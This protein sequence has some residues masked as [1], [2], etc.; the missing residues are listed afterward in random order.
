MTIYHFVGIKGTGM[1]PL[2]QILHD[3]NETVQGSDVEKRFF[4]Q[5]ALEDR[6]IPIMTFDK[7]NINENLTVIAGNAFPDH[8]EEIQ[9]ARELGIPLYR[10]FDFLGEFARQFT[11][12]A[13][14]GT[15][16]KTSTTGLLSH[17]FKDY[18]PTSYL[19][20]DGTGYAANN[21]QYFIFE[22]CEYRRH[23]LAYDPDYS[24]ITNI[25]YDHTD[26]FSDLEDVVQAFQ[27]LALKVK[28]GVIACGDDAHLQSIKINVPVIYYGLDEENDF[29]ARNIER[30]EHGT[31]FDVLVR[32]DYY[33]TFTIPQHGTHNVLN[34]LAVIAFCHYQGVP[35]ELLKAR[36]ASFHGVKRR[37]TEK[38]WGNQVIVDDYAHHP[39]EISATI[40]A[41][42]NKYPEREIVAIF[43]PHTYTRTKTFMDD[44][45]TSLEA[46]DEVYLCDIFGSAREDSGELTIEDLQQKI[47]GAQI[48]SEADIDT[49]SQHDAAVLLF[50]GAGDIQKYQAAYENAHPQK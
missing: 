25:D 1:S 17:V 47:P 33:G 42:K 43:Q 32:N 24:I 19:I 31:T 48:I 41:A 8:H 46:T 26:Y 3:M 34:A 45:A 18:L 38:L 30:S 2:A 10:Y 7:N 36:L 21:S 29:Q 22:A 12:V 39:T 4:T 37:F 15:H 11:S 5:K 6:N 35:T 20:G 44:F 49:L 13:V 14:T 50:M 16:G 9:Q 27:E 40:D 28:K 23:F